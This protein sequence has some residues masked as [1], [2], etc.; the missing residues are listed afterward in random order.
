VI[1]KLRQALEAG[2]EEAPRSSTL[3][4]AFA[5]LGE[6]AFADFAVLAATR[7]AWSRIVCSA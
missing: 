1:N 2:G 5:I 7:A 4:A 3:Y 6:T